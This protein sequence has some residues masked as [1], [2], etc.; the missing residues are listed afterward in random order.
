MNRTALLGW[1]IC[2][3]LSLTLPG[4]AADAPK[5]P[6]SVLEDVA[7][8]D[9]AVTYT[10]TK[11]P[12]GELIAKVAEDTGVPLTAAKD[13][14]DEPVAI[15]VKDLPARTLLIE[16]ADLLDYRWSQRTSGAQAL[17]RLGVQDG[18]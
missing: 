9:K 3:T 11:M 17:G 1:F 13:V 12:L 8:L 5:R 14:A 4:L 16:L 6:R 18:A 7:A 10:E 2:G 15:I